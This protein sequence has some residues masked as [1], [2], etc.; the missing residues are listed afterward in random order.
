MQSITSRMKVAAMGK[1]PI[2]LK[3]ERTVW[4]YKWHKP[5]VKSNGHPRKLRNKTELLIMATS[6]QKGH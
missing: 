1:G 2:K 6:R 5:N 3:D 4:S